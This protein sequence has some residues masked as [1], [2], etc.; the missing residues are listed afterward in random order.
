M[1]DHGIELK[2]IL[3]TKTD[4]PNPT[5]ENLVELGEAVKQSENPLRLGL[6]TDGDSDRFGAVDENGNYINPNDFLTLI[7]YHLIKNKGMSEGTI[8]KNHSTSD[9]LNALA[10]YFNKN[11]CDIDVKSTPVGFKYLGRKMMDLEGTNKEIILAGESSGGLTIRGHIPE[12][13]GFLAISL[14][15]DLVAAEKK[16][17]SEIL[18]EVNALI[19][20]DYKSLNLNFKFPSEQ[21]KLDAISTFEPYAAGEK[22]NFLGYKIDKEKT[23]AHNRMIK[24]YNPNGDGYKIYL[25]NKSSVLVRKSGTE[26]IMRYFID[27]PDKKTLENLKQNLINYALGSEGEMI[28]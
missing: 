9:K 12:K 15:A 10:D 24:E 16:P 20:A 2:G 5:A 7:A 3:S 22:D 23:I 21:Q 4:G 18:S 1:S 28:K 8:V 11:G 25:Q 26:P 14:L 17:V 27:S 19:N 13:D 6:A